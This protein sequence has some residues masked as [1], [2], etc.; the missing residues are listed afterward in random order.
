MRKLGLLVGLAACLSAASLLAYQPASQ[1][2]LGENSSCPSTEVRVRQPVRLPPVDTSVVQASADVLTLPAEVAPPPA[3]EEYYTLDELKGEMKKLVW[4]KGDLKIVPYGILWGSMAYETSRTATGDYVFYVLSDDEEGEDAF[5]VDGKST[6][7]GIDVIGPRLPLFGCAE[8]GG[9]IEF[10]FQGSFVTENRG[11]V[12]LRHAYLEVKN[13]DYRLLFGQTWDVISPLY[14][15]MLMYSVGWGG[16]NIGYRRA[17]FR[18]ERYYDLSPRMFLTLQGSLNTDIITPSDLPASV[19]IR[20]DHAGW[21]ILEGRAAMTLGER[22]PGCRPITIGASGHIGEQIYD[23]PASGIDDAAR[24]TWSFNADFRWPITERFGFQGEFFTGQ[25]LGAYLGGILQGIN[26]FTLEG[27]H[28]TGGWGEIWYDWSPRCHSHVGYSID[29]PWN[30]DVTV[31]RIYND[32]IFANLFY[33]VTPK[34]L[35]GVELSYWKTHY[36]T[37]SPGESAHIEFAAKYGF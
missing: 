18:A 32:F 37:Q 21:P 19:G 14:P 23:V 9:K 20:G 16:G 28:S 34:F 1:D 26:R 4:T 17:Q 33:D 3:V 36:Q 27:I 11:S 35:V 22:G 30:Q 8:S 2:W 12:L 25:N 31:G 7:L 15:G 13:E 29:D 5:H 10:D 6:R 24:K